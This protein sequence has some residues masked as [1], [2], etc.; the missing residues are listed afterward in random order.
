[1]T[2]VGRR[3]L[4]RAGI[5][6]FATVVAWAIALGGPPAGLGIQPPPPCLNGQMRHLVASQPPQR[7]NGHVTLYRLF[8]NTGNAPCTV[9]GFPTVAFVNGDNTHIAALEAHVH[10]Q[11]GVHPQSV[12]VAPR[13]FG[14]FRLSFKEGALCG[15]RTFRITGFD[16][17]PPSHLTDRRPPE[18]VCNFSAMVSPYRSTP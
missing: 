13:G 18:A 12:I 15:G 4:G 17:N 10:N 3:R 9:H 5:C 11:Q 14:Y 16:V 7:A 1:M 2:S 8:T 6:A